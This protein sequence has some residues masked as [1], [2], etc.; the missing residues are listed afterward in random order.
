MVPSIDRVFYKLHEEQDKYILDAGAAHGINEGAEFAIYKDQESPSK[1]SAL[2]VLVVGET[3]AFSA[4]MNLPDNAPRLELTG[5]GYALQTKTGE[6][7][8][9]RLHIPLD[10]KLTPIFEALGVGMC[11]GPDR[12]KIVLVEKAK[13]ELDV[14]IDGDRIVFNILNS[15]VTQ[16]GLNQMPYRVKPTYDDVY[17]VI[18]ASAHY[19]WHLRRNRRHNTSRNFQDHVHLEFRKL[20]ELDDYDDDFN[21]IVKPVGDNLNVEGVV[22]IVVNTDDLYGIKIVNNSARDLYPSLFFFDN[23]DLSICKCLILTADS[24]SDLVDSVLLPTTYFCTKIRRAPS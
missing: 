22:D 14:A 6:Q 15:Q 3:R 18:R 20:E 10:D 21:P 5:T 16:F 9:F 1:T 8:D 17:R 13:A 23:S 24:C 4:I 7:E 19:H 2:G 11:P 12:R